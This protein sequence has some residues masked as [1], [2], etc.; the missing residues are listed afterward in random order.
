MMQ[1]HYGALGVH[2]EASPKEIKS[3]FRKRAKAKHPD[4][5]LGQEESMRALIEAYRV[6][7]DPETRREYDRGRLRVVRKE[8]PGAFDY[9]S[10]LQERLDESPEYVAKLVF[11]DLL[12][13]LEDEALALYERIRERDDGRLE[14]FFER[15]EAMDAEFC[16]AEEYIARQRFDDAYRVMKK[17]IAMEQRLPGFGYFYEVVLARFKRLVLEELGRCMEPAGELALLDDAL[18]C[19]SGADNDAQFLRR[20]AELSIRLGDA[21]RATEYLRRARALKPKL[22]GLSVLDKRLAVARLKGA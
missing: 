6:L 5:A 22:P 17:L 2:P 20:A 10:W 4:L 1:D 9:H 19:R 13:G 12:H 18:A 15:P 7:S 8:G 11:Y 3:A 14:R 21:D 16:I